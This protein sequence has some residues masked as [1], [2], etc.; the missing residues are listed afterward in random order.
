MNKCDKEH[1]IVK[2]KE[3]PTRGGFYYRVAPA[4]EATDSYYQHFIRSRMSVRAELTPSQ[5]AYLR[6]SEDHS[7]EICIQCQPYLLQKL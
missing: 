5:I 3:Y 2:V 7:V 1:T 4:V 6:L